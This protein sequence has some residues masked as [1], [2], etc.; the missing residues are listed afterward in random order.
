MQR[1]SIQLRNA[2][3]GNQTSKSFPNVWFLRHPHARMRQP[4]NTLLLKTVELASGKKILYPYCYM[5]IED[6]LQ[7]LLLEPL[8]VNKCKEW[9]FDVGD[10][11]VMKV[12]GMFGGIFNVTMVP[13]FFLSHSHLAWQ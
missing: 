13:H 5:S 7:A 10:P 4:C 12:M 9:K 2:L 3:M 11:G 1:T 6:S 8:F